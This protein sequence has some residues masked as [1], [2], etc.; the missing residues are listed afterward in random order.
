MRKMAGGDPY[1]PSQMSGGP[2]QDMYGRP[3][4]ALPMNQ[5]PAYG[6]GYDRRPDHMISMDGGMGPPG[7]QNNMGPA[8]SENNM[9]APSR[10]PS[11]PRHDGF[12][13]QY[14]MH[15]GMHSSGMYP[16][17]QAY[18]RPMDGM[19][20]PPAKRHESDMYGMQYQN[21]QPDMYNHY[22][23]GYSGPE[24]RLMQG[25]FSYPYPRDRMGPSQS[26]HSMMG[27]VSTPNHVDGPNMWSSRTDLGYPYHNRPPS[28]M[29]PYGSM[30]REDMGEGRP[31]PEQWHRQ[32]SYMSSSM[33]PLSA[34]QPSSSYSG[35]SSMV[36]HLSRAP[37]PGAYQRSMDSRMSPAKPL[38]V[39]HEDV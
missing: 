12:G 3:P 39:R 7:S 14:S 16:Q 32:S 25:Q 15:Y 21:Q 18:K 20:G 1:M 23:G 10:Y 19:Y 29:P 36:N 5:R 8:N 24:H 11:Q 28:Q 27:G 2:M 4:S 26:Q 6:P 30:G 33:T 35:S 38:Y 31:G 37:S 13:Q 34:R 17:Q 22:G 9:Y